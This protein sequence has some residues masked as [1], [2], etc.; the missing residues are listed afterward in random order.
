MIRLYIRDAPALKAAE[1][2][3]VAQHLLEPVPASDFDL[4]RLK[5]IHPHLF[6]DVYAWTGEIRTVEIA[7]GESHFQPTRFTGSIGGNLSS[8]G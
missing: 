8:G 7:R 5:A 4:A 3:L 6:Q 1:R 2:E